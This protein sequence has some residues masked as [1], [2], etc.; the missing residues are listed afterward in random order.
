MERP[1]VSEHCQCPIHIIHP[2]RPLTILKLDCWQRQYDRRP[3]ACLFL[4]R[5]LFEISYHRSHLDADDFDCLLEFLSNRKNVTTFEL[6]Y[7]PIPQ[8]VV[9]PLIILLAT[10][11]RHVSLCHTDLPLTET[12]NTLHQQITKN[13]CRIESLRLSGNAFEHDHAEQLR[14]ILIDTKTLIYL[15]IGYCDLDTHSWAVIADGMLHCATLQAIDISDIRPSHSHHIIDASKLAL[16]L[17]CVMWPNRLREVHAKFCQLDGHDIIHFTDGLVQRCSNL[18]YLDLGGNRLGANGAHNLF[19]AIRQAPYL[20]GLDI[21]NNNIGKHGAGAVS[22][23]FCS[24]AI[25]YLDIGRNGIP[26]LEMRMIL[27]TLRK[28]HSIEILNIVGNEFDPNAA[29][30]LRRVIDARVCLL[31]SIDVTTTYDEDT[32]S[33][34]VVPSD[35]ELAQYSYRYNRVVP[36][37]RRY[38][39]RPNLQWHDKDR[40]KIRVNGLYLD[41]ICV[42]GKGRAYTFDAW[43]RKK[44]PECTRVFD[45]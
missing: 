13:S 40:P 10:N 3:Y 1:L 42:D 44:E 45:V 27:N 20:V 25:R 19:E 22:N 4:N 14:R 9:S 37:H 32:R 35:N 26:A 2:Y 38:D 18:V 17:S 36:F 29:D 31:H 7:I 24:T 28:V 6:N 43:G 16:T 21:S 39:A 41:A 33:F 12:F 8:S 11:M 15:D 5:K 23:M 30:V 34:R